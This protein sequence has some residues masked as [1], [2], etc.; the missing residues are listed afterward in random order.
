MHGNSEPAAAAV[1]TTDSRVTD[2]RP[3]PAEAAGRAPLTADLAAGERPVALLL[4]G[5]DAAWPAAL[6]E[7]TL[8]Q[9]R[10]HAWLTAVLAGLDTWAATPQVQAMGAF[11][12]G[13]TPVALPAD[14]EVAAADVRPASAPFA[15]VGA[16][17]ADLV[18]L[19]AL[20]AD[21]LAPVLA[22]RRT[23]LVGH[24]AGLLAGWVAAGERDGD[25]L[26]P[27]GTA[28]Q[29]ACIAALAGVHAA[30][31][32]WSVADA[33]LG[34]AL[35]GTQEAATPMMVLT[36]P[37]RARLGALLDQMAE[38]LDGGVVVAMANA[39]TR[40]V[41]AG[42]PAALAQ[43]RARLEGLTREEAQR[44]AAGRLGG[45]PL[46][47]TWEPLPSSAPFHHPALADAAA[48]A[49]AQARRL[50][51]A[52]GPARLPVLDPATGRPVPTEDPLA[53]ILTSVLARPHDWAGTLAAAVPAGGVAI[54]VGPLGSLGRVNAE[55]LEGRGVL[56][57][58]AGTR[59]G[60][61]ALATPGA[62]PAVPS[63]WAALAPRVISEPSGRLRLETRHTRRTGRSPMVLPG[64]T[65]TTA[66]APIVAAAANG[67][68]VAELAG[69]GQVSERIF[70]ERVREL[71]ELLVPGQEVVLNAMHLDPYLW[72]LHLG[73]ERLLQ[74]ARAT[75]APFCGVTI[76][77][78][79]PEPDEAV[80]LLD[81][82]A[83]LGCWLN[84]FKPGTAGQVDQVLAIAGR[85]ERP[86]WIHLE[87][88]AAG[89]HH[90]WE[91]LEELLLATYARVRSHE[92]VVL[93]VGGGIAGPDRAA[94]LLTGTWAHAHGMPAMPVD[95][96]LLGTVTMATAEAST[97]PSVKA[98]LVD[99]PGHA[100]WVAR[101]TVAGGTTSGRS[102]LDA[103]IHYLDNHASRTARLLDEVAGDAAAVD[104]RREE[105]AAALAGTAKPWFG[106][107]AEMTYGQLLERFVDLTAL[108]RHRRYD[109]G[110]WLD[111]S[112]RSRFLALLQRA[113][114]RLHPS[115]E[116]VV[117]TLFAD[118][119]S[120][121]DPRDALAAL[122]GA[123]P[124]A[125][126]A[127]L[128]P[129]DVDHFLAVCRRA[130]KPVPF[131][132]VLDADVRRWY[133]SD[134]LWQSHDDRY[135]AEQVLVIPGPTAV[136][137]IT[138]ADEPVADLLDR[139]EA[140]V[141]ATLLAQGAEPEPGPAFRLRPDGV[142]HGSAPAALLA[143]ALAAPTWRWSGAAR[144]NPLHRLGPASAWALDLAPATPAA[145]AVAHLERDGERARLAVD[146]A[147]RLALSILWPDLGLPGDG[148]TTIPVDVAEH[149]GTITFA[150][151]RGGLARAGAALLEV[152]GG[153]TDAPTDPAALA[154]AHAATVGASAPLPDRVMTALWPQVFRALDR[155]GQADGVLDLVH[156]RHQVV[157]DR[158]LPTRA[159]PRALPPMV[160]R[161][162]AGLVLTVDALADGWRVTDRFLVRQPS[163]D[164]AVPV[165]RPRAAASAVVP[166]P[167]RT[168]GTRT[169][170]AP[171]RLESFATVSGDPNPIHRSD[172]L[173]R[174]VGLPGRIVHGMWTSAAASR[175]VIETAADGDPTRLRDWAVEFVAPLPPGAAVTLTV[176]RVGLRAGGQVVTVEAAT[177]DGVVA[178]GSAEVAPP[179]TAYV[180]PGQG[181]QAQGMGMDGY[182]RSAA[183]RRVWDRADAITRERLGFSILAVVRD[184]P[185][186]IDAAGTTFR[187]PAGVLHLTQFTQVAMAT[188]AAAQVAE[189]REAGAWDAHAVLAGHSVGEYNALAAAAPVL[190][191]RAVIELV[192][193]RGMA[194]HGLVPRD[195]EG[196][197]HYRLAVIRPH[198][199]GLSHADAEALVAAVAEETGQLCEIVNHNLRGKQ[200]AVA[201][202][203]DALAELGRR[204]GPGHP[205]R[206][207]L[208]EVPGIDV[209]FHSHA[210]REGV[211]G[212]RE[213]LRAK[214]PARIDGAAL[215]GRYVPNLYPVAFRLDRDYVAGVHAVCGSEVLAGLLA[216]WEAACA[217]PDDLARTLL[218]ELLAWQFASPVRWIETFELLCAPLADGG[219]GVER[220]VEVGVGSA[221]TLANLAKG[222]LALPSHRGT[223]PEVANLELDAERLLAADGD[224][225]PVE[226]SEGSEQVAPAEPEGG[227]PAPT[228]GT[229][230]PV[231]D[232]PD[233]GATGPVADAPDPGATGPVADAPVDLTTALRALLALR[234]GVRADQLGDDTLD[235]LV[236][237]ASSRRNQLLMDLGREFGVPAIDGAHEVPLAELADRLGERARGYRFPGPVLAPGVEAALTAALGPLGSAPAA[238]AK[239]VT[240]HWGLAPGWVGRVG[241]AAALGSREGASRRGG[242]LRTLPGDRAE[243]LVDAAVLAAA[244][245]VGV[246]V[247][248][249]AAASGGTVDAAAVTELRQ[250]VEDLLAAQATGTL[251]R[252]GRGTPAEEAPDHRD[253]L[254]RLALLEAEHGPSAQVAPRFDARRHVLLASSQVWARADADHL[255]ECALAA[256]SA[257][258]PLDAAT[259]GLLDQLRVH[260][261]ADPRLATTLRFH[262]ARAEALG[263]NGTVALVDRA[264]TEAPSGVPGGDLDALRA[265]LVE[266]TAAAVLA[267]A[268]DLAVAPGAFADQVALV[269]GASPGSIA[270]AAVAHLLRGGATVVL[271]TTS[272]TPER[273]AAYRDLER[274]WAAPG[275]VLHV[276]PANLASF[277]D[278]D[279]LVEWCTTPTAETVGPVTREVK[280]ALLPTLL[281]PFAAAPSGGTLPD[282]DQSSQLT[283]RLLLLGVE[284]LVGAVAGRVAA[285]GAAPVTVVL[286]LSPNHGTFG[287]DG[288]YGDAK[289][290]LESLANR[291]HAEPGWGAHTRLLGAEIGWVRGTGLM[292]GND[293]A[294]AAVEQALGVTT[295]ATE[296]MGALVAALA[297]A[298]FAQRAAE[299]PLRVDLSG[300]LA[301]RTDLAVALRA[302]TT[303][304]HDAAP[305]Q[306]RA[307]EGEGAV[308]SIPALPNLPAVLRAARAAPTQP[309][310][311]AA[312]TAAE[313][314]VVLVGVAEIGPWGA[315]STRREAEHGRLSAAGVVEL[316]WRCGL[317]RWDRAGAHW[318]DL[319]DDAPIEEAE[320]ADRYRDEVGAR[321]GVRP[322][323]TTQDVAAEGRL[324][325]SEVFL[326]RPLTL[327]VGSPDEARAMAAGVAGARV[328]RA[329][330]GWHLTLPA[331]AAVRVPHQAPLA[332]TVGGQLPT[333]SDPTRHGLEPGVAAAMD[334]L[335]AWNLVVSAEA[336]ADAG[337][338]PEELVGAVHPSLV[339]NTQGSGMGGMHSIRT[340]NVGDLLDRDH[341][342]D[343]LQEALGNVV[344]A[345]ANQGLVGGYG[346]MVHPV[347]ACATAAVSLEEAIDKI[348]LGKAEVVLAGGWDDLGTE[349][350]SGFADMAATADN[351]AL[352]DAGLAPAQHSRPGDRRRRG[353]V[354]AQGG[355]SFLVCRG[356]VALRL[357]LPVRAVLAYAGSFGDGIHTSIPAPGL[358]ALGSVRGGADSPL[359]RALAELGLTA[360][361]IAV[362][363]KHDTSTEANDPNEA[364]VHATIQ[365]ALR[366]TPGNPLRVISQKALTGHA[367]GGAAAWQVAGLCDVLETGVVPG[368]PNLLSVDP[369]V[370]PEPLV[371][372]HRPLLRHE[373]VRAG[374]LTSLG[375]GHV[376]AVVALAHPD[377]FVAALPAAERAGYLARAQARRVAGARQRLAAQHAG[378]AVLD[379]RTD[380][381]LGEGT[382][383]DL[384]AREAAVLVDPAGTLPGAEPPGGLGPVTPAGAA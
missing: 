166:T 182:A 284:R 26:V 186:V 112:H 154:A 96:V 123:H 247:A 262:R 171:Q 6:A 223:R 376:S 382:A 65:P 69:G 238:L 260:R 211:P 272:D 5:I 331:G 198:L 304:A 380:R 89:G 16:V 3:T 240:G 66:E 202:T 121:D 98:A 233:P 350:I 115:D 11:P 255:V 101:G 315:S 102:G 206:P 90:S 180:F 190:P 116:G 329:E 290:A 50:G 297:T 107:V 14:A 347:A 175:A 332:R 13:F 12:D 191:L 68:H 55:V 194:M 341:A 147:G 285:A 263:R 187:H 51:L 87:G 197:S 257:G 106:D 114:A 78:G 232:A 353:F 126:T 339:G 289:A 134:A 250:H 252:L 118:P 299:G 322:L 57:V 325:L 125:A 54:T 349:G 39:P 218:V 264:L 333:G 306:A 378:P 204:L 93:A 139:F 63:P 60:R 317:I 300:G 248:P 363:S 282:T 127:L 222:A 351:R 308:A 210:L 314:M 82:L 337:V 244:S 372:D 367:K 199:A 265:V 323:H 46:A 108:G 231:A 156:L 70:T 277:A 183:A 340:L 61:E 119:A 328:T 369:R 62:A 143:A 205:G 220:V 142:P 356:S 326:D 167:T 310:A 40:H 8:G 258:A 161:T 278:V 41:L 273:I 384:R 33:A 360:D 128:H 160:T 245:E 192:F 355:G 371:V 37:R 4:P 381:R 45:T 370:A 162:E 72:G 20:E 286:P 243:S 173:A 158:T 383:S 225:A 261:D 301:G 140:E 373:P 267:A 275:A 146:H 234:A 137:G 49:V 293:A 84:A 22:A 42:D 32:P 136:A 151:T 201:T 59:A 109:D 29:A 131:V 313:D 21:G 23:V 268:R 298:G 193:A 103:D 327:V 19:Q 148:S 266:P 1:P 283:L 237:G 366:R 81:E 15:L 86:L 155:A 368:N 221:P 99:A 316:A 36:G 150:V 343:V 188:L 229:A 216:D 153:G 224:P 239:R 129:A 259:E 228:P 144:P 117:P 149:E 169:V 71:G 195:A 318:V 219:L 43:F 359:G 256:E 241:L 338:R 170:T 374:L 295:F 242:D 132:P 179:R 185:T 172:L 214:L 281:L 94:A 122:L 9:P 364:F 251:E 18:A 34:D 10:L 176:Q 320:A 38:L 330:D 120:V 200:Y 91:D 309:E 53:A 105:I 58:D 362:V 85:T 7:A 249:A 168:L 230:G 25:G 184:N 159:E 207:P 279:A 227:A 274:R 181:I 24:S 77:A 88:G 163:V 177:A 56:A 346:P 291:W 138:R 130:G 377:V 113:E 213:H 124:E 52:L 357:G 292:A 67:G 280:P 294:A 235:T 344:P 178:L 17:L 76:S 189:L 361:D 79:I 80:A 44:R 35:A 336:L 100:G 217:D 31:H 324:V 73:H 270:W 287:G 215:V 48:A 203:V 253:A 303:G 379:R 110:A 354:E 335:A 145:V 141:V 2:L 288:A 311:R 212:F 276:V 92:H 30:R 321:V 196:R 358:G 47:V 271:A 312:R 348:R 319:V 307:G 165:L 74:R 104:A 75:G 27:V 208:L 302:A 352:L 174:L 269:T 83:A 236:E 28:V 345:H 334:P 209:P 375:F 296:Q 164:A 365:A 254:A 226:P 97:S 152:F 305:D 246:T 157:T 64:M 95:A 135:D 342:N 133:A 111:P